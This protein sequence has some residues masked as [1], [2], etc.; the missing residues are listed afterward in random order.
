MSN[1]KQQKVDSA[2][3]KLNELAREEPDM[4]PPVYTAVLKRAGFKTLKD[5]AAARPKEFF[6]FVD[7]CGAVVDEGEEPQFSPNPIE[8]T[9]T[10]ERVPK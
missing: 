10:P 7:Q 6:T 9:T 1:N 8:G 4:W 3:R 2:L 5:W